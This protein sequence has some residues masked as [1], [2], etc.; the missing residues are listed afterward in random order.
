MTPPPPPLLTLFNYKGS[1]TTLKSG[2]MENLFAQRERYWLKN[3][4]GSSLLFYSLLHFAKGKLDKVEWPDRL[5]F[6]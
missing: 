4:Q 3:D 1:Q 5:G 2:R 6:N